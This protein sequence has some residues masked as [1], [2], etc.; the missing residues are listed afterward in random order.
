MHRTGPLHAVGYARLGSRRLRRQVF[1]RIGDELRA[2]LRAAE[3]VRVA[4]VLGHETLRLDRHRHAAHRIDCG[5]AV[6]P[7]RMPVSARMAVCI[8]VHYSSSACVWSCSS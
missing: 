2:A 1:D 8:G 4:V 7:L 6:V 5:V 3:V